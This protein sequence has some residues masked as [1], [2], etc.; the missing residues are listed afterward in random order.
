MSALCLLPVLAGCTPPPSQDMTLGEDKPVMLDAMSP[1][2]QAA[3]VEAIS[4]GLRR[5][6]SAYH[7]QP[8]DRIEVMYEISGRSLRPYRIGIRDE[9]DLD[10]QFD[11]ELNRQ[12]VVRPDGMISLP[13]RGEISA[14]ELRPLQLAAKIADR[15]RDIA[16]DPVVTVSVRKFNSQTD[17][18]VQVVQNSA[19]G[20]AR[21]AVVRPDGLIDLPM[22]TSVRAAG[23]TPADLQDSL[24]ARYAS[25]IGG[26]KTTVR[27]TAL[28]ANQIFVFGEVKQPGGVPAPGP[29]TI[30]Q[31]VA[32]AGGPLPTGALD[33]VR[34]LY[35]DPLGR[36]H[37]RVVNLER[38]LTDLRLSEDMIVPPNSTVYVPPTQLAK[39]GRFVD[40]LVKQIFLYN[41]ISI[42][43]TPWITQVK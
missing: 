43:I 6:T 28:A 16:V 18:L 41:G 25:T 1:A 2:E 13:G 7:L 27:V 5:G 32:A 3:A 26:V 35:F 12:V 38:V 36:A 42:G 23:L 8:G 10:F 30:M 4:S 17:E 15:Y 22:A 14:F 40:Q 19:E 39:A 21:S 20:R 9:L 33:Q 31:T 29:R 37:L 24:D 34:V 11:R